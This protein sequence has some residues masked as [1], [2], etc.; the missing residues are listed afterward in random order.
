MNNCTAD[1]G[2]SEAKELPKVNGLTR[3]STTVRKKFIDILR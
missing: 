1:L 3:Y 2:I